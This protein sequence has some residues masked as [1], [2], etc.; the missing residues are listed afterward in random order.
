MKRSPLPVALGS[1]LL[2][3][4]CLGCG[5]R[6]TQADCEI[7]VDQTVAA[8]LRERNITDPATVKSTQ[9]DLR[10]EVKG[11]MSGC[12]GRHITDSAMKCIKG[13]KTEAEIVKCLR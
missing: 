3:G 5:R 12:V 6:A 11:Q 2:L 1:L 10:E 7:I 13:A 9:K 4:P 8:K